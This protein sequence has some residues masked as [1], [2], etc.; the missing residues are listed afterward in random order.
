MPNVMRVVDGKMF[1]ASSR[2]VAVAH[3]DRPNMGEEVGML[4]VHPDGK[5]VETN[6]CPGKLFEY[7]MK[8]MDAGSLHF[9]ESRF[10]YKS[11]TERVYLLFCT[12]E[13]SK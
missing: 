10:W 13:V 1:L 3:F 12:K 2:N 9:I 5:I 7:A 8:L 6:I 4:V 11:D